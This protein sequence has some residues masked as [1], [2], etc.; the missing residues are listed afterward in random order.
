MATMTTAIRG[1]LHLLGASSMGFLFREFDMLL[2]VYLL[3]AA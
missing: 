1:Q 2:L 3:S